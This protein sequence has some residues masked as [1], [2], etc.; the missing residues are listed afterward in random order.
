MT[1]AT[2]LSSGRTRILGL[3]A[4][5][6]V[7]ANLSAA[8]A[9][10]DEVCESPEGAA[11]GAAAG[12]V[13]LQAKG[14]KSSHSGLAT[15]AKSAQHKVEKVKMVESG[16]DKA[17]HATEKAPTPKSRE[18]ENVASKPSK[19]DQM[20]ARPAAPMKM[21][22]ASLLA[23]V[24]GQARA[25]A[26]S[27]TISWVMLALAVVLLMVATY[28]TARNQ[29]T[30]TKL[31]L[32]LNFLGETSTDGG[33]KQLDSNLDSKLLP[34]EEACFC[35]DLVVPAG[36]E[37][38]LLVP[39]RPKRGESFDINDSNGSTVLSVVE[40]S[41]ST[42][43]RRMLVAG[44]NVV[45][46]QCG[47]VQPSL[48]SSLSSSIAF[49]LFTASEDAWAKLSYEP[50]EGRE[51]KCTI[52]TK[53]GEQLFLVGSFRHNALNMTDAHG[54]LIA[55]TELMTQQGPKGETAGSLCRLRVAPSAD[56]GLVLCSL[57]CVQH[58]SSA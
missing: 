52:Q 25:V 54:G 32:R 7:T 41:N 1:T 12:K 26:E 51:D 46:A 43:P 39:T 5:I 11:G 27:S 29:E 13:L 9:L 35:P 57:I 30:L 14:I 45:L 58:L 15:P 19:Q 17:A 24:A 21:S 20:G 23:S 44:G 6:V 47:R 48:P 2:K 38:I 4:V 10:S 18:A 56:V 16:G 55:T 40:K 31:L 3:V 37:C 42:P 8:A 22:T 28:A 49:E 53:T 34:S 36:C 50:G 33:G